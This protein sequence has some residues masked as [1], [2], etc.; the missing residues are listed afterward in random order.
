MSIRPGWFYHES[1]DSLVKTP[2]ELFDI[3]LTSVGRGSVLLLNIPP[4][5]RGLIH[6]NDVESLKGFKQLLDEAFSNNLTEGAKINASNYRGK[7]TNYAPANL[8]DN[9]KDTYWTTDDDVIAADLEIALKKPQLVSYIL[10]QEHI[11]LG[12]R[13][14]SF[15][16]ETWNG[17]KWEKATTGTTI[18]HKR[19]LKIDPVTTSKIRLS[20]LDSKASPVLANVELY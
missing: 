19:I 20:I 8:I 11:K 1:E 5:K 7:S 4:D 15:S 9:N 18:G 13:V 12:Q 14:K 6:E 10:L 17:H 2:E 3:Y 16:I